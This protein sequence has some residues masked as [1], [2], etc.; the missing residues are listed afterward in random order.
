M[1]EK[2][3]GIY[4]ELNYK[5]CMSTLAKVELSVEKCAVQFFLDC[6]TLE[7]GTVMLS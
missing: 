1:I 2:H 3:K 4:E 6:L 7:D 5:K